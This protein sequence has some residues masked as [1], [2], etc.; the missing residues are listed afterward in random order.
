MLRVI[1]D[2]TQYTTIQACQL[3][4]N[5]IL[6][7]KCPD[8]QTICMLTRTRSKDYSEWQFGFVP[9]GKFQYGATFMARTFH[10]A[11]GKAAMQRKVYAFNT[12]QEFA[13]A[14]Y[15]NYIC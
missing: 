1:T 13:V 2:Q 15:R 10:Q 11:A 3:H 5:E 14:L 7:Y 12:V 4:G 8:S 6:A 9:I